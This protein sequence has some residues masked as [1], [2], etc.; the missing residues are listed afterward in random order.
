MIHL[1]VGYLLIMC[2]LEMVLMIA[3]KRFAVQHKQRIPEKTLLGV[4]ALGG[5]FGGFLAMYLVHHKTRRWYF[6]LLMP[7]LTL[8]YAALT[9]YLFSS[10]ALNI[11]K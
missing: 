11:Y 9:Y 5:A 1:Y 4:A 8:V 2:I 7:I 10:G 3:D 6:V